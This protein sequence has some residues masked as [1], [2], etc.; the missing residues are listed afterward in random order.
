MKK[1]ATTP[2]N[3]FGHPRPCLCSRGSFSHKDITSKFCCFPAAFTNFSA[4]LGV[5]KNFETVKVP[6]KQ[7]I[8]SRQTVR[9]D[10]WCFNSFCLVNRA[11]R[12]PRENDSAAMG[13][14]HGDYHFRMQ[15]TRYPSLAISFTHT[16]SR[17]SPERLSLSGLGWC[18]IV[19]PEV[20]S[21]PFILSKGN[22][23][24]KNQPNQPARI[25]TML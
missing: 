9:Q 12:S 11:L 17:P 19:F 13:K 25:W 23:K 10:W 16:R 14:K 24:K 7:S 8:A 2:N 18:L 22:E 1:C 15:N 21:P 4:I 6:G 20:F 5:S 3:N